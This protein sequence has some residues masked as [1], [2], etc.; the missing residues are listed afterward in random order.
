MSA[1]PHSL[2]QSHSLSHKFVPNPFAHTLEGNIVES[3][4]LDSSIS[5]SHPLDS[6]ILQQ[7]REYERIKADTGEGLS[8]T[9]QSIINFIKNKSAAVAD[10]TDP[11][12]DL[13]EPDCW[14]SFSKAF[15]SLEREPVSHIF[16]LD[17]A[18]TYKMTYVFEK[19]LVQLNMYEIIILRYPTSLDNSKVLAYLDEV[20]T[21]A[22]QSGVNLVFL[23]LSTPNGLEVFVLSHYLEYNLAWVEF[24]LNLCSSAD[25]VARS[26][27]SG[28]TLQ[29]SPNGPDD[30]IAWFSPRQLTDLSNWDGPIDHDLPTVK[31]TSSYLQR[32]MDLVIFVNMAPVIGNSAGIIPELFNQ[33]QY[34]YLLVQYFRQVLPQAA[35]SLECDIYNNYIYHDIHD[36]LPLRQDKLALFRKDLVELHGLGHEFGFGVNFII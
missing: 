24:M 12:V 20:V 35:Q 10:T 6:D 8:S 30:K 26:Y 5:P 15:W 7:I 21:L 27:R 16:T 11:F 2:S 14:A 22:D 29:L 28:P 3:R 33:V 36:P 17:E 13:V 1:L 9:Q 34:Y 23:P 25:F 4:S 32:D 31:F 19:S 18:D